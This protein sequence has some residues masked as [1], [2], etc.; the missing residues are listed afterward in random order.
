MG[1]LNDHT[2]TD[3]NEVLE[4]LLVYRPTIN[5]VLCEYVLPKRNDANSLKVEKDVALSIDF[6]K[7]WSSRISRLATTLARGHLL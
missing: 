3:D 4:N 1:D 2:Q 7:A 6:L 5:P